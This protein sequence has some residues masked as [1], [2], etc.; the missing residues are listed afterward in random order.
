MG[1]EDDEEHVAMR[2]RRLRR[3]ACLHDDRGT[4]HDA[5]DGKLSDVGG[6]AVADSNDRDLSRHQ[7]APL[8]STGHARNRLSAQHRHGP[9][10]MLSVL[11]TLIF[12]KHAEDSTNHFPGRIV[13]GL[14]CDGQ[15]TNPKSLEVPLV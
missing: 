15:H 1:R 14:L 6:R 13:T 8:D 3:R 5:R 7:F 11:L 2:G 12:I 10:G 4:R 9:E